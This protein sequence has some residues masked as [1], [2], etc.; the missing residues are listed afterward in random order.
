[1]YPETDVP[2]V[3]PDLSEIVEPELLTERAH[4]Y[5]TDLGLNEGLAEQVAFG[6]RMS[7]FEEA[8]AADIDPTFAAGLLESTL[9]E[10]RRDSVPIENLS[11][12]HLMSVMR[13]VES[14]K[15]AKEG[16]PTVLETIADTPTLSVEAAIE[17]AGLGGV[18]EA[19]VKAA[20]EDIVERNA[21]QVE[22]EGMA[23]FSA[24]MGEAMGALRGK[25]DGE[26]VSTA[27]R[28]SIQQRMS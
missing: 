1:M 27:L 16:V 6:R 18:S 9:T 3:T 19:E 24:L 5:E 20:V 10:L 4:R 21:S 28:E 25:A 2:P 14:G 7:L 23:A 26:V 22:Q 11:D 8:V 13:A 12:E 17:E 15:L